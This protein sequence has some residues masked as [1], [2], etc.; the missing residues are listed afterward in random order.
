MICYGPALIPPFFLVL[1][2][3]LRDCFDLSAYGGY[4]SEWDGGAGWFGGERSGRKFDFGYCWQVLGEFQILNYRSFYCVET[5][6]LTVNYS[7][8]PST[9]FIA[10]HL[11]PT[12]QIRGFHQ[13]TEI[14]NLQKS[15]LPG[16]GTGIRCLSP[17][18]MLGVTLLDKVGRPRP[19]HDL[20]G[21]KDSRCVIAR[22]NPTISVRCCRSWKN[23]YRSSV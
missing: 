14:C 19:P 16:H 9:L 17:A 6:F 13:T 22:K 8:F 3:H 12:Y 15:L 5:F 11:S 10:F 4:G 1:L 20:F 2:C 7:I 23:I 18:S 21:W